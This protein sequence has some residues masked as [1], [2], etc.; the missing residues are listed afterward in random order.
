MPRIAMGL[1]LGSLGYTL[2][3]YGF[4][5][6]MCGNNTLSELFWPGKYKVAVNDAGGQ[7]AGC[8]GSSSYQGAPA[9]SS[10]TNPHAGAGSSPSKTTPRQATPG[11][12]NFNG[13]R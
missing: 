13:M 11:P 3:Y 2:A 12:E 10:T 1:V 7:G 9:S 6:I 8:S 5:R 4:Q